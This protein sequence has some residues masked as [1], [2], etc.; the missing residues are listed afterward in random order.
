[1]N[2]PKNRKQIHQTSRLRHKKTERAAAE[3]R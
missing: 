3:E 2:H 1:M